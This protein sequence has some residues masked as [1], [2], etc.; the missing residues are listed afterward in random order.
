MGITKWTYYV[1]SASKSILRSPTVENRNPAS[2]SIYIHIYS[3]CKFASQVYI[4]NAEILYYLSSYGL[5]TY[6]G[7]LFGIPAVSRWQKAVA[8]RLALKR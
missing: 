1:N 7:S 5:G 6:S 2:A 3:I 8:P 4:Y